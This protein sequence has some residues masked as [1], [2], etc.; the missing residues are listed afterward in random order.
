MDAGGAKDE[1]ADLRTVLCCRL[2]SPLYEEG[3]TL[4]QNSGA[5]RGER[6]KLWLE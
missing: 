5:S 3:G 6:A 2:L 4:K 1:G